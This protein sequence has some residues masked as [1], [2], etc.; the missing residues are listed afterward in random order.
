MIVGS[1]EWGGDGFRLGA[2]MTLG[3]GG[4][5]W[6][7]SLGRG[8]LVRTVVLTTGTSLAGKIIM[9]ER[10][11][12]GRAGGGAGCHGNIEVIAGAWICLGRHKTGTPPVL[13]ARS[14]DFEKALIQPGSPTPLHFSFWGCDDESLRFPSAPTQSIP[15]GPSRGGGS[16]M[17]C[18]LVST[19]CEDP[20][21]DNEQPGPGADVQ[22]VY[23]GGR[24]TVLP[25]NRG[26]G[27]EVHKDSHG[28]FLEPEGW[29]TNEVYL[30]GANTSLPEDVQEAFVRSIAG[31]E[32]A[33]ILKPG[34]AIEYDF[35][36]T[37]Q[38]NATMESKLVPNL[39]LA[40]Q[41]CGTSGYEEAAGQGI[42]AGI[43]AALKVKGRKPLILRRDQAY[44]G[45]MIDDLVTRDHFEPYR[46]LTSRAEHRLLL[47]QDNA[48]Q[49]LAPIG[50][51]VGLLGTDQ[52]R[53]VEE[54]RER[55]ARELGRLGGT[56]LPQDGSMDAWLESRGLAP[57]RKAVTA[58]EFLRRP[59]VDYNTALALGLGDWELNEECRSQVE[60]E[61]KYREYIARQSREVERIRRLE[62][63]PISGDV[64]YSEVRGLSNEAKDNLGKF[65]PVT[66]GQASR[67]PGVGTSDISLLL[68]H[69]ER[70]RD[71]VKAV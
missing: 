34:Y 36:L 57:V 45:V 61:A 35:V 26:Q 64:D 32:R 33:E 62:E 53:M 27:G 28:L 4:Y 70:K 56:Y 41:V 58:A 50:Y 5:G 44:L 31:L 65:L 2:G 22:R 63:Q 39:F 19:K 51:E 11:Y 59:E 54:K 68:V 37:D 67:V 24:A 16:Q 14:I 1:G 46:M 17:A 10:A 30:Q 42:V 8:M 43:N 25:V 66:V 29:E 69:L 18:Y 40:G 47:R 52:Y 48:D 12:T 6:R 49:R 23:R 55:V 21:G 60:I 71:R 20:R 38:I 13:D 7:R 3:V 15:R 9:G